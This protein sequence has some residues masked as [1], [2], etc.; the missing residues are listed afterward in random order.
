MRRKSN[1]K[2]QIS[3]FKCLYL[4]EDRGFTLIE[5]LVVVVII[6]VL[7][8]LLMVNYISVRQR[9]RDV[10]RKSD[11]RQI[12]SA[13]ELYKADVGTYPASPLPGCD[14]P[15]TANGSTYIQKIPCDPMKG[16]GYVYTYV[17]NS[18]TEYSLVA[19]L[20]NVNDQQKDAVNTNYCTGG[21]TNW[22]YTLT[23]P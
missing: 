8:T 15:L 13:L 18:P 4:Q 23:N 6:G 2:F 21:T 7:A 12:Q 11:L 17:S 10:E 9:A 5:L 14:L 1:F 3:N 20:E 22:S 16:S 19:C